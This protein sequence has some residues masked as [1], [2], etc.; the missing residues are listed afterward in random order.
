MNYCSFHENIIDFKV[1]LMEIITILNKGEFKRIC[2]DL[3]ES[4]WFTATGM[5]KKLNGIM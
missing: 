5:D 1:I 3:R 2:T 4:S